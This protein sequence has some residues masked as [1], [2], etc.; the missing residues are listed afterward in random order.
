[1]T[2]LMAGIAKPPVGRPPIPFQHP[3]E[4][5]AEDLNGVLVTATLGDQVHGDVLAG[6]RP[7]PR[8]LP[9]DSPAG[10]VRLDRPA[11]AD[12]IDQGLI[13]RLEPPRLARD[14]LH[15]PARGDRDPEPAQRPSGLLRRETQLLVEL[16]RERDR[17]RTE[18]ASGRAQ[19]V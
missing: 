8:L 7:Q 19:S 1:M 2:G 17:T 5:R 10:L 13:S 4:V 6:E 14:R 11:C 3:R 12:S 15:H 9:I 16:G 18:H